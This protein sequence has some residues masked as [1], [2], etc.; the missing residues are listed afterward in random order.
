MKMV[1]IKHAYEPKEGTTVAE[2]TEEIRTMMANEIGYKKSHNKY[3]DNDEF[4]E[5]YME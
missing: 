2:F 5:M 4:E 3:P 1:R